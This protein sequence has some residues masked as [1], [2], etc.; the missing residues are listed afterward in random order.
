MAKDD[1]NKWFEKRKIIKAQEADAEEVRHKLITEEKKR[2]DA[3]V[4]EVR[5]KNL[6]KEQRIIDSELSLLNKLKFEFEKF[7]NFYPTGRLRRIGLSLKLE[8]CNH[9]SILRKKQLL[10]RRYSTDKRRVTVYANPES[11]DY[12]YRIEANVKVHTSGNHGES[13]SYIKLELKKEETNT[14]FEKLLYIMREEVIQHA[15]IVNL[16][17]WNRGLTIAFITGLIILV[18][19]KC[20]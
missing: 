3:K 15:E 11:N 4:E 10:L 2:R 20:N 13:T 1:V 12:H 7:Y 16:Y 19:S 17:L 5:Q 18:V 14:P 6:L 8:D 9:Y